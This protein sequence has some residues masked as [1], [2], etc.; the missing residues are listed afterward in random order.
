MVSDEKKFNDDD[1]V[2]LIN[3]KLE[4][5]YKNGVVLLEPMNREKR[6]KIHEI[7]NGMPNVKSYN[8]SVKNSEDRRI[9]LKHITDF[10]DKKTVNEI[11]KL[12]N[13]AYNNRDYDTCI[14][15]YRSALKFGKN[16]SY[17]FAKIGLCYKKKNDLDMANTYLDIAVGLL[18]EER[19]INYCGI[20]NI[21]KIYDLVSSGVSFDEVC[22]NMEL[23]SEQQSIVLSLFAKD[24]Y[25]QENYEMGD[26]F[27]KRAEGV[28]GKTK[29]ANSLIE[30]IRRNKLFYKGQENVEKHKLLTLNFL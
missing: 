22:I 13:E 5:L 21:E 2:Q 3:Q 1:V 23:D 7:V 14:N 20:Y 11:L 16:D 18:K 19:I 24:C 9:F 29:Y 15:V 8:I 28:K 4:D 27:L 12:G 10:K 25:A 6:L 30:K 17:M 26:Q